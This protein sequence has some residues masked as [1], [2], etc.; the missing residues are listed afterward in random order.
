MELVA[1]QGPV[2][3]PSGWVMAASVA[4]FI[5]CTSASLPRLNNLPAPYFWIAPQVFADPASLLRLRDILPLFQQQY[6]S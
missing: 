3:F 2:A 5:A 4:L 6:L 1:W